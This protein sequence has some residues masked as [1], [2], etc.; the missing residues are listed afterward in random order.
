MCRNKYYGLKL[1]EEGF[2]RELTTFLQSGLGLRTELIDPLIHKLKKLYRVIEK[3]QTYR[4]YSSSLLLMYEGKDD[5]ESSS[6]RQRKESEC[7]SSLESADQF[8]L[9][10]S[11]SS[12]LRRPKVDVRMIDFAHTTYSGCPQDRLRTGP[13]KGYLFGIE[14]L[15][16][17]LD[18][19]KRNHTEGSESDN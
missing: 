14:N 3:L 11:Q 15:I 2:K 18:E 9:Q 4:F 16:K 12:G 6:S 8:H 1:T 5:L 7:G 10:K 13:D 19:I 17:L